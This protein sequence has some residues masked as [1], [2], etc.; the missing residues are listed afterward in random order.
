[1][2]VVSFARLGCRY[3]CRRVFAVGAANAAAA[4]AAVSVSVCG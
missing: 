1:M 2:V 4:A 3:Y